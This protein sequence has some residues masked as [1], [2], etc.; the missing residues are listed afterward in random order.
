MDWDTIN[1]KT[2][3]RLKVKLLGWNLSNG[4]LHQSMLRPDVFTINIK[5]LNGMDEVYWIRKGDIQIL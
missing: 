4:G 1:R 5:D 3:V 2:C